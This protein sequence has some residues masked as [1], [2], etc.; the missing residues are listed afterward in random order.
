MVVCVDFENQYCFAIL[1]T[2]QAKQ[3]FGEVKPDAISRS[4]DDHASARYNVEFSAPFGS[5]VDVQLK[6][7]P[8]VV[9]VQE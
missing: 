8:I 2:L 6:Y 7:W 4:S 9:A 3:A 5:V 1:S